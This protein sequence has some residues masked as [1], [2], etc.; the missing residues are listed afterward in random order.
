M[1]EYETLLTDNRI[2][3]Q[4]TVGI[5]VVT[6]TCLV[7]GFSGPM[8]LRGLASLGICAKVAPTSTI[9]WISTFRL[10]STATA[11]RSLSGAGRGDAPIQSHHQ[12]VRAMAEGNPG[13]V[14]LDDHKVA[15]PPREKMKE[16]MEALIH[17]FK[18]FTEGYCARGRGLRGYRASQKGEYGVYL[19]SDG[20]NKALPA[21]GAGGGFRPFVLHG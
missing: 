21:Q 15:P 7:T 8:L 6:R 18:L 16:D 9:R 5:G 2:W 12:T 4:R 10:A 3:K 1:D 14:I 13:P 11:M 20:A 17:H 19:I